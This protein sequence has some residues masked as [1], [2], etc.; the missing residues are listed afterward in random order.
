M[1]TFN[2][3]KLAN[4]RISTGYA[5]K[6]PRPLLQSDDI[7]IGSLCFQTIWLPQQSK[8]DDDGKRSLSNHLN[9]F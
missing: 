5:Q 2:R 4:T 8:A 1:S 7:L 9:S 3:V 6:S